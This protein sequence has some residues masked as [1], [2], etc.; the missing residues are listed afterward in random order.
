MFKAEIYMF[1]T[2][3]YQLKTEGYE[4]NRLVRRYFWPNQ[5]ILPTNE[6]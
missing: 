1:K 6:S 5:S 3:E 2:E 4:L